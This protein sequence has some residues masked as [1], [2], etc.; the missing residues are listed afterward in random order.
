MPVSTRKPIKRPITEEDEPK[1]PKRRQ[2]AG[3]T[4]KAREEQL[5]KDSIDL[6]AKQIRQGT[7]SSQ[8]LNHFLK[9]GSTLAELEKERLIK[10]NLLLTAKTESLQSQKK[11]EELYAN[12]L[13][14]MSKYQ[15]REE[16]VL[17][18]E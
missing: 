15:G 18:D 13:K 17:D 12:A 4:V 3:K 6:A 11:V 14:A 10:E 16:E 1:G 2:A 5:I 9:L 8:N 7:I